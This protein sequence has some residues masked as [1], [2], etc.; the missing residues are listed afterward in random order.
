[1]E[2]VLSAILVPIA[3]GIPLSI[4]TGLIAGR[5]LVFRQLVSDCIELLYTQGGPYESADEIRLATR[6]MERLEAISLRLAREGHAAAAQIVCSIAREAASDLASL[7]TSFT[8]SEVRMKSS[9][10]R[11]ILSSEVTATAIKRLERLA[12]ACRGLLGVRI[13]AQQSLGSTSEVRAEDGM[14]PGAPQG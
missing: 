14:V 6:Q 5:Y 9:P 2:F 8:Y 13:G 10:P 4:Y 1:M 12:P 7:H 3:V 11:N